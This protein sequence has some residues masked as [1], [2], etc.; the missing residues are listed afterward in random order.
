MKAL[1]RFFS[2]LTYG[3]LGYTL[4]TAIIAVMAL[5]ENKEYTAYGWTFLALAGGG[6]LAAIVLN[7]FKCKWS[8]FLCW[9]P[10]QSPGYISVF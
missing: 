10:R 7:I 5:S 4:F 8:S 3:A 2:F 9:L 6:L 1:S